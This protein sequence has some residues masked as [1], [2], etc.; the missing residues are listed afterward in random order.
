MEPRKEVIWPTARS[1][2]MTK[3][4]LCK[5]LHEMGVPINT[6]SISGL[7]LGAESE[8]MVLAK[9]LFDAEVVHL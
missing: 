1:K 5:S 9:D 4:P 8:H 2:G 3:S 6:T 7:A